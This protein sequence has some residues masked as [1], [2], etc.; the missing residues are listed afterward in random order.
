MQTQR[1]FRA[2]Q[3]G[4]Y[5]QRRCYAPILQGKRGELELYYVCRLASFGNYVVDDT[6][7][8]LRWHELQDQPRIEVELSRKLLKATKRST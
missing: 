2:I 8:A 1:A 5:T 4:Q 6:T 7:G 3:T